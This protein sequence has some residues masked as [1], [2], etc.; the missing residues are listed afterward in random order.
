MYILGA[1]KAVATLTPAPGAPEIEVKQYRRGDYFGELAL[2]N[3]SPRK[4]N[5]IARSDCTCLRIK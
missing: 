4:A 5:V 2:L 3:D 1:G